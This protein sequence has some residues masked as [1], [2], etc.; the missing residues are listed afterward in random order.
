M[1]KN[2]LLSFIPE[3]NGDKKTKIILDRSRTVNY[4][5]EKINMNTH[6]CSNCKKPYY[7]EEIQYDFCPFCGIKYKYETDVSI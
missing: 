2:K 7:F 1:K 5:G 4:N 6:E 3:Y